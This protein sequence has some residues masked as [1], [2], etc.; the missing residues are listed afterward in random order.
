MF[1]KYQNFS[2]YGRLSEGYIIRYWKNCTFWKLA[3]ICISTGVLLRIYRSK[4]ANFGFGGRYWGDLK[5]L[6]SKSWNFDSFR[7]LWPFKV[8]NF[9]KICQNI[10]IFEP[11]CHRKNLSPTKINLESWKLI[12]MYKLNKLSFFRNFDFLPVMAL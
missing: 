4:S 7:I 8:D 3:N 5:I 10:T 11:N 6:R 2:F 12:C 1:L 9:V